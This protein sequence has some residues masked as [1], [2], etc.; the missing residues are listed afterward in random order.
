MYKIIKGE[1]RK[2]RKGGS[3]EREIFL[4]MRMHMRIAHAGY[5]RTCTLGCMHIH[6]SIY[7]HAACE[8]RK[9]NG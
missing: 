7:M 9:Y 4:Y 1:V 6:N 3:G 8:V 5:A 2:V